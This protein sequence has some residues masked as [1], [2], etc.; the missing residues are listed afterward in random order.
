MDW[1]VS[2]SIYCLYSLL[3]YST[4]FTILEI[5]NRDEHNSGGVIMT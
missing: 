5:F 4:S 1:K 2:I 3:T